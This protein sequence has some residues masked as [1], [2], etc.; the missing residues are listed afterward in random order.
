MQEALYWSVENDD[1][2]RCLLCPHN[3]LIAEGKTGICKVRKNINNR[4]FSLTYGEVAAIH[5][6]PVEKKPL[7]HFYPGSRILSVGTYGCNLHCTFCQNHH[8]S[9]P[10]DQSFAQTVAIPPDQLVRK[11]KQIAGNTGIAYTYNEPSV[12]FEFLIHTAKKA[13]DAGLKNV[14]VSN[15][16]LN[17]GP[18][19]ELLPF[20]DAFNIDLKS[21]SNDF[22]R[23]MTGGSLEP[24]LESLKI[25]VK[26]GRHLEITLLV[27]PAINDSP[28]EFRLMTDWIY[29]VLGNEIP[30]HLSR[31]FPS[32]KL[33]LPPTPVSTILR[34]AE[35]AGEKLDYVYTGN[36]G[37]S[38]YSSTYCPHC[39]SELIHRSYYEVEFTGL[40]S[41]GTCSG[42]GNSIPVVM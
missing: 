2:V 37:D 42:C 8:L 28:D 9:Q 24:V 40:T 30:F 29:H 14:V 33:S 16:Y 27:I 10:A 41:E 34:F 3:C 18:L 38:D 12:F 23:T 19:S 35:I 7:Y 31:Y 26:A 11:A 20:I 15:G 22:Y 36:M 25:I 17:P 4:L 13:K 32:Y 21:F 5:S 39:R 1:K 6:D